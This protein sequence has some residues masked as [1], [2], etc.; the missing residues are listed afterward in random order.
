MIRSL[1]VGAGRQQSRAGASR[2]CWRSR[3]N[4][5]NLSKPTCARTITCRFSPTCAAKAREAIAARV[6]AQKTIG[7][8]NGPTVSHI[9]HRDGDPNW[10]ALHIIVHR[11]ELFAA[12]NELRAI[13]GSGVVVAPVTYIFEEEP[14]RYK[15]MLDSANSE[16]VI[17]E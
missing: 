8:L 6:F 10:Y 13:G 15:A 12:I 11:D 2:T 16:T 1:A 4:C 14:P 9:I 5:W 3:G 17:S 7:G